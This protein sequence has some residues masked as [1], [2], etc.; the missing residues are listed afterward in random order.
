MIGSDNGLLAIQPS[1][2]PMI[3]QPYHFS[4]LIGHKRCWNAPL[5]VMG[6]RDLPVF[7]RQCHGFWWHGDARSQGISSHGMDLFLAEY[8]GLNIRMSRHSKSRQNILTFLN[9]LNN[10]DWTTPLILC[11][12][13]P[14]RRCCDKCASANSWLWWC[15][16]VYWSD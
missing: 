3:I 11:I 14:L 6:G 5:R 8:F 7:Q 13:Q 16:G 10:F 2:R 9:T 4:S 1:F 15:L 12:K